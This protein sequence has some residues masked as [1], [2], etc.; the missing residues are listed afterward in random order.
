MSK[1]E[2]VAII[3]RHGA[4]YVCQEAYDLLHDTKVGEAWVKENVGQLTDTGFQQSKALG[5]LLG[6]HFLSKLSESRIL[7]VS[8]SKDRVKESGRHF[9]MGLKDVTTEDQLGRKI[10]EKY[11]K[12]EPE[13]LGTAGASSLLELPPKDPN[14][15]FRAFKTNNSYVTEKRDFLQSDAFK[16][17][18]K[19]ESEFLEEIFELLVPEKADRFPLVEKL[20]LV[21]ALVGAVECEKHMGIQ[22]LTSMLSETQLDRLYKIGRWLKDRLFFKLKAAKTL[23]KPLLDDIVTNSRKTKLSIYSAHDHS[24]CSVLASLGVSEY[25]FMPGSD[26]PFISFGSYLVLHFRK[27]LSIVSARFNPQPF[28][29]RNPIEASRDHESPL[30][31]RK[32]LK[33]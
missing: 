1:A 33:C 17:K 20:E 6:S 18:A 13:N 21:D 9:L 2:H 24:I 27:D 5:S 11:I 3:H 7:W 22:N 12:G 26:V 28:D 25:P 4:R 16:H 23:G 15:L 29:Y 31:V 14:D 10:L 30:R 8:S 32:T 19:K